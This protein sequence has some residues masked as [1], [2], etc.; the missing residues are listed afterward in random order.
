MVNKDAAATTAT[1]I[2]E[3]DITGD[4]ST[5]GLGKG[6]KPRRWLTDGHFERLF[7]ITLEDNVGL[8]KRWSTCKIARLHEHGVN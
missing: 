4:Y 7:I 5:S 6:V 2:N 3:N 1:E 8:T